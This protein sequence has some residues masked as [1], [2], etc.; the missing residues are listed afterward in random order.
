[1]IRIVMIFASA[2]LVFAYVAPT[3]LQGIGETDGEANS[4]APPRAASARVPEPAPDLKTIGNRFRVAADRS[5]HFL[6]DARINGRSVDA[7][8]DTGATMVAL[9]YEDARQMGLIKPSDAFDQ[10]VGTANGVARARLVRLSSVKVGPVTVNDVDALVAAPGALGIN[11]LGMTFLR[12]LARFEVSG[13][14]LELER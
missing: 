6:V 14:V 9:R 4:A 13:S 7:V 10:R 2:V 12:R 1:M 5:G 3:A 11:L 8:V